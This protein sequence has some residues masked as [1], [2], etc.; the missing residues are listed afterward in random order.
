M[1]ANS[2]NSLQDVVAHAKAYG[3]IY[4][5]S[6]IYGGLQAV[7]DYGP[8][9]I[10]L[11]RNVQTLWWKSMTQIHRNIV[12]IDSAIFMHPHTWKASGHTDG[13]NDLM[14]DNKDSKKRYRVDTLI[15]EKAAQWV[16]EQKHEAADKLLK[17]MHHY[18]KQQDLIGLHTLLTSSAIRCP[19]A[20]TKHWTPIRQFNLMFQTQVGAVADH[21]QH[22]HLRPETAQG[23]FVNFLNVQKSSRMKIPFGIAQIGKAFRNEIVARQFIFRMREFEQMEMQFFVQPGTEKKWF[24]Y[25]KDQRLQWHTTLGIPSSQLA[26]KPH[27]SLAHYA[28]DAVDITFNF[29]FGYKEIEGIHSR[30]DFD[31][32][33]HQTH[34][35][36][37]LQYFDP[38]QNEKYV[39]YVI[40]TS[41]GCDR[42]ILMLL[43]QCLKHE[44]IDGTTKSRTYL[45]LP[46]LLAPVQVA[47][48]PLV[49][50][51]ALPDKAR[52]LA[53]ELK[54]H[55][56]TVYEENQPIGKRYARQDLIGTPY[57]ITI[58]YQT[59]EDDTVTLRDR[60][61]TTQRRLAIKEIP[62]FLAREVS[63]SSFFRKMNTACMGD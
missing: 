58:D 34:A 48:F 27:E 31:L 60:D 45:K 33:N 49:K 3:F 11:K 57:C 63:M 17:A 50:K 19:I 55:H 51:D 10:A 52:A 14:V 53:D 26:C 29:P 42:L 18:I 43:C 20:N 28:Q 37:Q 35:N 23:I 24:D 15:E 47:V 6:E 38:A 36:K 30:T 16:R 4:P 54:L 2:G 22:I 13:F 25:W 1:T 12:G 44:K 41:L 8:H 39:P 62:Y 56:T 59:L 40:E 5:S 7:Y 61:T 21:K 32:K 46:P 9:G